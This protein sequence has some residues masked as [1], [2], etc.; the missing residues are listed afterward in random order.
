[1]LAVAGRAKH[2]YIAATIGRNGGPAWGVDAVVASGPRVVKGGE[3]IDGSVPR[4][5]QQMN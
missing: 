1:M 4:P 2:L 3:P 5:R